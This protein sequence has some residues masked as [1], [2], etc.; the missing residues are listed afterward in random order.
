MSGPT[1]ANPSE[2]SPPAKVTWRRLGPT[3]VTAVTVV[4]KVRY[5]VA[6][7]ITF[8]AL[9]TP[10]SPDCSRA[11]ITSPNSSAQMLS[12]ALIGFAKASSNR[13]SPSSS[14]TTSRTPS[15]PTAVARALVASRRSPRMRATSSVE[16]S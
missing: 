5:P 12:M 6:S 8:S 10:S 3:S 15:T 14:T 16:S 13:C 1:G 9:V 2:R 7:A 11:W 4:K